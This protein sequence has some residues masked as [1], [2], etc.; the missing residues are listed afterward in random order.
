MAPCS[1]PRR[2]SS[3]AEITCTGMCRVRGS[4]LSWSSTTQ[5]SMSG[6]RRSSVIASGFR[7]RASSRPWAPVVATTPRKPRSRAS[8]SRVR[9][10]VSSSS[11][12]SSTRSPGGQLRADRRRSRRSACSPPWI[13][14]RLDR[15]RRRH[16]RSDCGA[17]PAPIGA[18]LELRASAARRRGCR[19]RCADRVLER[20]VQGEG[21]AH[22]RLAVQVQ[23]AAQQ[24]GDLA[25]DR[26]AQARC[27][28]TCGWC[29][30]RPAG[31]PR[32]RSSA[33][34]R[35]CRCRCR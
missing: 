26:E 25:A 13:R 17:R 34:P 7:M 6:R 18:R 12:I 31:T 22:A 11:M 21:A 2:S 32:R 3:S 28:R 16:C 4:C 8:P 23:L 19:R 33:C 24:A 35:G 10:K 9:P 30:R 20:Q 1:R 29:R 15:A 27:R 14:R 5:P